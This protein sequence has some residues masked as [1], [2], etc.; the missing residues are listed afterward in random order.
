MA[1]LPGRAADFGPA[2]AEALLATIADLHGEAQRAA[3][4]VHLLDRALE[5]SGYQTWLERHPDGTSRLRLLSRLR[6]LMQRAEL[7]LAEW[8]D[9]VALGDGVSDDA[10]VTHLSSVH[11]AKGKEFAPPASWAW[12]K[13]WSRTTEPS[14]PAMPATP[15]SRRSCGCST[16]R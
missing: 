15:R 5:R 13:G 2:A 14:A 7:P 6:M 8:L 11:L 9:A 4:A 1:E 12:K 3:S 16:W 10:E